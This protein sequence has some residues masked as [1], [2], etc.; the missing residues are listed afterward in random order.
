MDTAI[1]FGVGLLVGA[2]LVLLVVLVF[3]RRERHLAENLLAATQEQKLAEL[4][5][6]TEQI[7]TQFAALSREALSAN[8]DDFLKLAKTQIEQQV[9]VGN[10]SLESKKK[11]IDA[12]LEAIGKRL[13]DMGQTMQVQ[14][15]QRRESHGVLRA[16][17][18]KATQV[19]SHLQLTTEQL[20]RALANPQRRGQW[21][22]RIAEE[23]LRLAG[24]VE[25]VSY[26]KQEQLE[27]GTRPDFSFPLPNDQSVNM[28]V[29]FPL[30]NYLRVQET[31][32][33]AA[34]A[35]L[36][37]AF[38]KDVRGRIKEVTSRDYIDPSHGTV[39]Y[40]LV[41]IPNE[42][43]H[44][45]IHEHDRTLLDDALRKKVVLC[46][47]LTLYAV[48]AVMRH[49]AESFR[50]QQASE[51][52]LTLFAKFRKQW[53]KYGEVTD[54]LGKKLDE[55]QAAFKELTTTRTRQLDRQIDKI[56]ELQKARAPEAT[57][58]PEPED[59]V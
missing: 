12:Q 55:A 1:A 6:L 45:F 29:K 28:D 30:A 51:E 44:G 24:F 14:E 40:V 4:A 19:T 15:N 56:D 36:T 58:L 39:D 17:I 25:G 18:E 57:V 9:V 46:S 26:T 27:G 23:V 8:S 2:G 21:G 38:L 34:R 7:K 53:E 31:D 42:Q 33:E 52:I 3:R 20:R 5:T 13:T 48:L 43:I 50:F 35:R 16:Q 22:E 32:D 59:D 37:D 47:P 49:V 54:K 41:F 10:Q 11:L